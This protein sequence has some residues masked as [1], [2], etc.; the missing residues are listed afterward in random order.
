[1]ARTDKPDD[2]KDVRISTGLGHTND[3][4]DACEN[5]PDH[6]PVTESSGEGEAH[7]DRE[8]TL[9]VARERGE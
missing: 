9:W 7:E 2:P 8:G 1:M 4:P 6:A 3:A 5:E